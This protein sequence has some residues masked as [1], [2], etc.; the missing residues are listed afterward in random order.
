MFGGRRRQGIG[1]GV[2]WSTIMLL[3]HKGV[4]PVSTLGRTLAACAMLLSI[5]LLSLLTGVIA[6]VLTVH[7]LDTGI[8]H[9]SDLTNVRVVT[10]ASSTSAE[11]LRRRRV[12]F[13]TRPTAE[14]VLQAAAEGEADAAVYD[15]ALLKYLA[16]SGFAETI[17]I[18]PIS[19]HTQEYAIALRPNSPL[20]KP[21]NEA[22]L[23]YRASD[24]WEELTYRYLG[25]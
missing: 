19:F 2:W 20:R 14:A 6:S 15:D 25:E 11:Y 23:R 17:Q 3:G 9:P 21:L 24:G 10:V 8:Y 18:L 4:I 12:A 5:L 16:N 7:Q 22:M 13:E 1:M